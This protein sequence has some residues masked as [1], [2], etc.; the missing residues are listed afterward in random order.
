LFEI[1][2]AK[3]YTRYNFIVQNYA[4]IFDNASR[5]INPSVRCDSKMFGKR[6]SGRQKMWREQANSPVNDLGARV[7]VARV[8]PLIVPLF[9]LGTGYW[10]Y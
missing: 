10:V 5:P 8:R 4:E 7:M 3:V 6:M 1:Q 9:F 2:N